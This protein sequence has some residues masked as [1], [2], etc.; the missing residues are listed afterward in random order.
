MSLLALLDE[1]VDAPAGVVFPPRGRRARYVS[2]AIGLGLVL[3]RVQPRVC[4]FGHH[5]A[6]V[7]SHI[8]GVRCIGLNKIGRPGNLVAMATQS[9]DCAWLPLAEW[10]TASFD[11]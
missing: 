10:P 4:F 11:V 8:A 2:S 5:H 6:R 7:D 1:A 3:Q 9:A